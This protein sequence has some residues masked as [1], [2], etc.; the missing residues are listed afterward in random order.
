MLPRAMEMSALR[1]FPET[2]S[3]ARRT[4]EKSFPKNIESFSGRFPV[5]KGIAGYVAETGET[6]NVSDVY[7]DPRFNPEVDEE[8]D[9]FTD[10]F[11]AYNIELESFKDWLH[12][13]LDLLSSAHYSGNYDRSSAAHQQ[14]QRHE[15]IHQGELSCDI[16]EMM[17]TVMMIMIIRRM[18]SSSL[19]SPPSSHW[20]CTTPSCTTSSG[21]N[22][23]CVQYTCTRVNSQAE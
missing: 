3:G 10:F 6:L 13:S 22:R 8:V 15:D 12:N 5:G 11:C 7:N 2:T 23:F 17:M 4:L 9:F 20:P 19:S 1:G 18:R 14:E 16:L 21:N